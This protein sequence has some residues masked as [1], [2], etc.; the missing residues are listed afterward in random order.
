MCR[1]ALD[2]VNAAEAAAQ[3]L[4]AEAQLA[5]E[6]IFRL[7]AIR[8]SARPSA[9]FRDAVSAL[10]LGGKAHAPARSPPLLVPTSATFAPLRECAAG[11]R[12][13]A[14]AIAGS[15]LRLQLGAPS[16][17]GRTLRSCVCRRT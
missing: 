13:R 8:A 15:T 16:L 7:T 17:L 14:V 9:A 2:G 12:S 1:V 5:L 11:S 4:P 10:L 6:R 3:P